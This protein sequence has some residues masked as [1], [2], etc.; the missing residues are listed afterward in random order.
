MTRCRGFRTD[1][2]FASELDAGEIAELQA[3]EEANP[4]YWLLTCG[5]PP[6][7]D[8]AARRFEQHPPVDMSYSEHLQF[9]VQMYRVEKSAHR[10]TSLLI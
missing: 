5:H 3:F 6:A 2:F 7:A 10:L 1:E 8:S 9:L 4:E